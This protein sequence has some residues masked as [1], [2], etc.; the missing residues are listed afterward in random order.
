MRG[1]A[2]LAALLLAS[3]AD[4]KAVNAAFFQ[5]KV[6]WYVFNAAA[7]LGVEELAGL[8]QP[9]DVLWRPAPLAL[10]VTALLDTGEGVGAAAVSHLGFLTL[11]DSTGLLVVRKAESDPDLAAYS[12]GRLF[13]W[14]RK[15]FVTLSQDSPGAAPSLSLAW[16]S[17]GQT[18]LAFYPLVSQ[19]EHPAW[20]A[21]RVSLAGLRSATP[22]VVFAWAAPEATPTSTR[23]LLSTGHEEAVE[24]FVPDAAAPLGPE[25]DPLNQRLN[26]RVGT[27]P[28]RFAAGTQGPLLLLTPQGWA[29]V[30]RAGSTESRLYR[31]P[32]I[33][34]AGAYSHALE[35]QRGWLIAWQTGARGFAGAAGL[36]YVPFGVLAP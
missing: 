30:G 10:R 12:T 32:E 4:E 35:L 9:L 19:T 20:Q 29:A 34:A 18:R 1:L 36:V 15:T 22:S 27:E 24:A 14:D 28:A 6:T 23:L 17:A 3:C 16:W 7:P 5:N 8:E 2:V 25:F 33:S 21:P 11:D 13:V 26:A 31:L